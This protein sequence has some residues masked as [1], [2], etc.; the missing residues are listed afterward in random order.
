M[1]SIN[2]N[3]S[4]GQLAIDPIPV[5]ERRG[6]EFSEELVRLHDSIQDSDMQVMNSILR[7]SADTHVLINEA[8]ANGRTALHVA[9]ANANLKATRILIESG[10]IVNSQDYDGETPLH[11]AE[12]APMTNLLLETGRA[13]PNIPSID[14]ICALHLAVQRKDA[15]SVRALLKHNAKVDTADNIRWLTPLHLVVLPE[16]IEEDNELEGR[17]KARKII[18]DLLCGGSGSPRPCLDEQDHEGNTPLHYAVQIET[19]DACDVVNTLLEK[20]ADPKVP[21]GRNQQPLLLLCH[22]AALRKE[23]V[24]QECLHSMLFH[25]ADPNQQSNTGCTPLHLSLYHQDID[26]AVQL[27]NRASE[28]HLLWK[29]VRIAAMLTFVEQM[30]RL[31]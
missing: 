30:I 27:V 25:G 19:A 20:G 24:Y 6:F 1:P 17:M 9:V 31:H 7:K 4:A 21:N 10:A 3:D 16:R 28:L 26:S 8:S 22:N 23:D 14:G 13:N 18:V 5:S 11:L 15:G 29:K 12:G 2:T